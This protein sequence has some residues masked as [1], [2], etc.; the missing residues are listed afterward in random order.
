MAIF[1]KRTPKNYD[2]TKFP[3][4]KITP[5]LEDF[6]KKISPQKKRQKDAVF[7][8]WCDIIG[9]RLRGLTRPAS[10]QNETLTV[11]IKTHTLYSFLCMHEKDRLLREMQKKLPNYSI[12]QIQFR[13]GS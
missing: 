10:F 11:F 13:I 5:L 2:G 1:M 12:K 3:I 7:N 9:E 8:A 6:L 4:K